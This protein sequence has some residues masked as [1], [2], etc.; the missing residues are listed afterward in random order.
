MFAQ[1]SEFCVGGASGECGATNTEVVSTECAVSN[2]M[3]HCDTIVGQ[4]CL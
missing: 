3:V 4:H 1:S 2:A